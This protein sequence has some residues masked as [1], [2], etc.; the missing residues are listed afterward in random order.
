MAAIKEFLAICYER[1]TSKAGFGA[2]SASG[3]KK[4]PCFLRLWRCSDYFA[5]IAKN[6]MS[7]PNKM[8]A[9]NSENAVCS[10]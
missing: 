6:Q 10:G 9:P 1:F 3:D 4:I 7:R 8:S 2:S 5:G